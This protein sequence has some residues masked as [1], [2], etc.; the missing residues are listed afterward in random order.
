M[1]MLL[2]LLDV[3]N[4]DSRIISDTKIC[5]ISLLL[6]YLPRMA[7]T[8]ATYQRIHKFYCLPFVMKSVR[9]NTVSKSVSM[10]CLMRLIVV[11]VCTIVNL[12]HNCAKLCM[13]CYVHMMI[14]VI[15]YM[16]CHACVIQHSCCNTN[17][18][19]YYKP[20]LTYIAL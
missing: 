17:K 9:D 13:L 10:L 7:V 4:L 1:F 14:C 11:S 20:L 2:I 5:Q 15:L 18:N 19:H 16:H 12:R 8:S 6:S 3:S